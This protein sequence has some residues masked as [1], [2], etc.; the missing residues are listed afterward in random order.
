MLQGIA[1]R[2]K[3]PPLEPNTLRL[4]T[5]HGAKGLEFDNVWVMGL[6]DTILPSWQ[7]LKSGVHGPQLEEERRNFFVAIT[8]TRKKLMLSYAGRYDGWPKK[9]SRFLAELGLNDL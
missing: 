4:L 7:S 1:L 6:A 3:G 2:P 5:I 8:R 9:P